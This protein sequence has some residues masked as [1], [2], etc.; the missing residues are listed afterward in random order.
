MVIAMYMADLTHKIMLYTT[1]R[2]HTIQETVECWEHGVS[3]ENK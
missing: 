3:I 2:L 1:I